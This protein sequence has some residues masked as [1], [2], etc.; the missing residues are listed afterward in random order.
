MQFDKELENLTAIS[1]GQLAV[2]I[3]RYADYEK[4]VLAE[5]LEISTDQIDDLINGELCLP[6]KSLHRIV[7]LFY[8]YC[9]H[10]VVK[11]LFDAPLMSQ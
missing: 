3:I 9:W 5:I 4:S 8:S 7:S 10:D 6:D 2:A 11:I 1:Y